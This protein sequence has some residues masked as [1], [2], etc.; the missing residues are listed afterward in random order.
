MCNSVLDVIADNKFNNY[1]GDGSQNMSKGA[2]GYA[3]VNGG[4]AG[5]G[6]QGGGGNQQHGAG[7]NGFVKGGSVAASHNDARFVQESTAFPGHI[8]R[9]IQTASDTAKY[10][11]SSQ[12][13][14]MVQ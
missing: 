9:V 2:P 7:G 3:P 4:K 10:I 6:Y 14:K 8:P 5:I 11:H 12:T 1:N 13:D